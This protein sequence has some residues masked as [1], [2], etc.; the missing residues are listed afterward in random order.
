MFKNFLRTIA[1]DQDVDL[2]LNDMLPI[3]DVTREAFSVLGQR[4]VISASVG[5]SCPECTQPYRAA[6]NEEDMDVDH[7]DVKMHV[8]EVF[9]VSHVFHLD[10]RLSSDCPRTLLGLFLSEI[11]AKQV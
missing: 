9:T 11:T 3:N 10:L 5:H 4:G 2:K 8:V 7:A 1:A 6:A